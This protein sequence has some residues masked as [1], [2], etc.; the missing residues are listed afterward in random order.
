MKTTRFRNG[1]EMPNL[2]LGTWQS[3]PGDVHQAVKEAVRV[4]YRH[5]DCA[6]VYRNEAEVGQ[7]L[8]E[9]FAEGLVA[10]EDMWI[11]SK[12]WNNAHRP[13]DVLPALEKTLAD[14][15]LDYVD[16]YLMHW[17]IAIRKDVLY[18]RTGSDLVSL[19]EL[20]LAVTWGAMEVGLDKGLCKH[21]GVSNFSSVKVRAL[22]QSAQ[23][24]PEVNQVELHPYLQQN[25][26]LA[27]CGELGL[28][29]TGYSPLGS[30][31]RP[32]V[33]RRADDPILLEDAV[34]GA[35]AESR[36]VTPAQV[37]LSWAIQRGTSVIPKS[38]DPGRIKQNLEA[39]AVTLEDGDMRRIADLDRK[40]RYLRGNIWAL[41]GSAY[42]VD[43]LWDE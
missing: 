16:L 10:R 42:T 34:I 27:T 29:V 12:L 35:I 9:C 2:G 25:E 31:N 37:L 30:R 24:K 3:A 26:L 36:G 41:E 13:E 14:L 38:V 11:T 5:I 1:D 6:A 20:P 33:V 19:D 39:A 32:E 18:P 4:G 8:S 40:R 43:N 17:P 7:A 28:A 21:L 23:H 15:R 22:A